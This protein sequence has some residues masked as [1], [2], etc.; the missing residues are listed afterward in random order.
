VGVGITDGKDLRSIADFAVEGMIHMASLGVQA[1]LKVC[2]N[3]LR[4]F[5][6]GIT[7]GRGL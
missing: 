7:D 2:L 5:R 4:D 6:V 1:I 3:S